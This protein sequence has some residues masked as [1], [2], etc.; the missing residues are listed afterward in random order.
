[1]QPVSYQAPPPLGS[2]GAEP[3]VNLLRFAWDTNM[4]KLGTFVGLMG[5]L[6]VASVF[7]GA[8]YFGVAI[9]QGFNFLRPTP[10]GP[11][12]L[13]W[14]QLAGVLAGAVLVAPVTAGVYGVVLRILRYKTDPMSGFYAAGHYFQ[15]AAGRHN[16]WE[17]VVHAAPDQW[18]DQR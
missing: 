3:T 16:I 5:M 14:A 8:A 18:P 1:M 11:T 12:D 17:I 10:I 9:L 2:G 6:I 7:A 4:A 15:P 13:L